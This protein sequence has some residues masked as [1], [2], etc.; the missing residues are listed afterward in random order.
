VPQPLHNLG[1]QH[2]PGLEVARCGAPTIGLG[3]VLTDACPVSR[4][5]LPAGPS[6][7]Q[8]CPDAAP[9]NRRP[10]TVG[11]RLQQFLQPAALDK[12]H[13][14]PR[15]GSTGINIRDTG[16]A[17]SRHRGSGH[18]ASL[19][20]PDPAHVL[21]HAAITAACVGDAPDFI[22]AQNASRTGF[23]AGLPQTS[24]SRRI[25]CAS[26]VGL[27]GMHCGTRQNQ[28]RQPFGQQLTLVS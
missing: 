2:R 12:R 6:R 22:A 14:P 18:I 19:L 5:G 3:H 4:N 8:S 28:A 13:R 7:G 23:D 24:A 17:I 11:A 16:P 27:R 20:H 10:A 25:A 9:T 26:H 15:P 1:Q 21:R